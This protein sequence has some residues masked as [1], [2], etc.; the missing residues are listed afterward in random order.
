MYEG[1]Y[2]NVMEIDSKKRYWLIKLISLFLGRKS[3]LQSY[4]KDDADMN[5]IE[6]QRVYVIDTVSVIILD[7]FCVVGITNG[8]I[9]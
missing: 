4:V 8:I 5:D 6:L 2:G 9:R 7:L 1:I 3:I